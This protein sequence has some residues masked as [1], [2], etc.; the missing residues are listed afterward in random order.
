MILVKLLVCAF[1][2]YAASLLVPKRI[3]WT[4]LLVASVAFYAMSGIRAFLMLLLISACS[5]AVGRAIERFPVGSRWRRQVLLAGCIFVLLWL[6]MIKCL[7]LT[8]HKSRIIVVPLGASYASFS[9][10]SYL[11]DVYWERDKADRNFLKHLLYI[12]FFPKIAEGPIN[13]HR[14]LALSLYEGQD[15]TYRNFCFGCQR[16]LYGLFKKLVIAERLSLITAGILSDMESYSGSMIALAML[17]AAIELYCDFSGYM[18]IVLGFTECLGMKMDENFRHPFFSRSAAE[19]WRRWHI[20]LGVWFK[21]Y[22]YLPLVM[23]GFVK[24]MGRWGRKH[25]GKEFGNNLMKAVSL[26]AVWL[27]TGLWH[28]TGVNYILWGCMWGGIIIASTLLEKFYRNVTGFLHI[29]TEAP[30]W[31]LFQMLRTS[32]IFCFGHLLTRLPK[33]HDL[34]LAVSKIVRDFRVAQLFSNELFG[35]GVPAKDFMLLLLFLFG[36]L[37]VSIVQERR[38]V[39][40]LVAGMNAPVRWAIYAAGISVV[41][42]F[43]LYGP[44][45]SMKDFVYAQF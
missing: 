30:S 3:R 39:R 36:L 35:F 15:L 20:T 41:V 19:F 11:I 4:V 7:A 12:L 8:G 45:H 43:G 22:V 21:D 13:K 10:L 42:F 23:T 18:D 40:E 26:A 31:K 14:T 24:K 6:F 5:F 38:S 28:G 44:G 32:A 37:C 1:L 2:T 16:M 17:F 27:L 9:I 34:G 25:V 33:L 29:N